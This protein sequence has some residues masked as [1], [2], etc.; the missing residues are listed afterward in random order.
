MSPEQVNDNRTAAGIN[1]DHMRS[2]AEEAALDRWAFDKIQREYAQAWTDTRAIFAKDR[3]A[4]YAEGEARFD[5]VS[6]SGMEP[7]Q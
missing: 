6:D 4:I 5:V 3:P 2:V 7:E 1:A